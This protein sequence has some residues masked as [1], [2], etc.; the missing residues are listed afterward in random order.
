MSVLLS[1]E[2]TARK[3]FPQSIAFSKKQ[4]K[5]SITLYDCVR[6]AY[7]AS[8]IC[9]QL[10]FSI[11]RSSNGQE[12]RVGLFDAI[13][14]IASI[15]INLASICFAIVSIYKYPFKMQSSVLQ[16]GGRI[17]V[18]CTNTVTVYAIVLDLINRNRSVKI[19]QGLFDFDKNVRKELKH[20]LLKT[21]LKLFSFPLKNRWKH[22]G[23]ILILSK[24]GAMLYATWF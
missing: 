6:P 12:A 10:P 2:F 24:A 23:F 19:L 16:I 18:I 1:T 4:S 21:I 22:M 17:F 20:S 8:R 13:W 11:R 3:I 9:G 14:F 7:I 15:T 5:K